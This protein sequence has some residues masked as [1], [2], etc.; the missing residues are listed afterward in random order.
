MDSISSTRLVLVLF[1]MTFFLHVWGN[2]AA[3]TRCSVCGME[4]RADSRLSFEAKTKE[5]TYTLCSFACASRITDKHADAALFTKDYVT[6]EKIP[7]KEGYYLVKSTSLAG[8]V[9]MGMP[10]VVASFKTKEKA[11]EALKRLGNGELKQGIDAAF[12]S[13]K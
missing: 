11:E 12:L 10:P 6:G 9:E 3:T 8:E 7:A 5:K 1:L 2:A 4:T 13:F